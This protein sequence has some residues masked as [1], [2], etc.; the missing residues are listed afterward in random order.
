MPLGKNSTL[1]TS[2]P[3][4]QV[5]SSSRSG[6]EKNRTVPISS[7]ATRAVPSCDTAKHIQGIPVARYSA[8]TAD[9][10]GFKRETP[11]F[12]HTARWRSFGVMAKVETFPKP[13]PTIVLPPIS[14]VFQSFALPS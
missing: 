11:L 9:D 3:K 8:A 2:D 10:V 4:F 1:S 6:S 13:I 12:V 7:V 5:F 14:A